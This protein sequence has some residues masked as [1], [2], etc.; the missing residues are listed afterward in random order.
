MGLCHVQAIEK[1]S[2]CLL[3]WGSNCSHCTSDVVVHDVREAIFYIWDSEMIW[4]F[5]RFEGVTFVAH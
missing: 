2:E 3:V 1:P 4:K 5:V